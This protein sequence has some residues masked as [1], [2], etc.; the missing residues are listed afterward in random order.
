M[1]NDIIYKKFVVD[2]QGFNI[3]EANEYSLII[4]EIT[5]VDLA[6][7]NISHFLASP[8]FHQSYL[9]DTELKR[10]N[11]L[12]KHHHKLLWNDGQFEYSEVMKM[13]REAIKDAD[14][15]FIKGR[16]RALFLQRLTGKTVV[17][18]D[19]MECPRAYSIPLPEIA[20]RV[21]CAHPPHDKGVGICSLQQ[22]LKFS[23]WL[24]DYYYTNGVDEVG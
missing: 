20:M 18:L 21:T 17:D 4:K 22:A 13:V 16:E 6:T 19:R 23:A 12:Q 9:T 10:A 2:I 14:F 15:L 3:E 1:F 11:W 8:P 24:K 7:D 5:I